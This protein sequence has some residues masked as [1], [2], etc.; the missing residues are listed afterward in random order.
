MKTNSKILSYV[1]ATLYISCQNSPTPPPKAEPTVFTYPQASTQAERNAF[2][3]EAR[4]S[5]ITTQ[6]RNTK[7]IIEHKLNQDALNFGKNY[8]GN[9][10]LETIEQQILNKE[11]KLA[12]HNLSKII[13]KLQKSRAANPNLMYS[14]PYAKHAKLLHAVLVAKTFG[15]QQSIAEFSKLTQMNPKWVKGYIAFWETLQ[16]RGALELALKVARVGNDHTKGAHL[17]LWLAQLESLISLGQRTQAWKVF[18]LARKRFPTARE[19]RHLKS[20]LLLT[21]GN[22]RAACA[23][24]HSKAGLQGL[25]LQTLCSIEQGLPE[26]AKELLAESQLLEPN[27]PIKLLLEGY[28]HYQSGQY[29]KAYTRFQHYRRHFPAEQQ[30]HLLLK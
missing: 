20:L 5:F 1:V 2:A 30:N 24:K 29:E 17:Q 21:D 12:Y 26:Q 15:W 19:L 23:N 7:P 16:G 25:W 6:K 4:K 9:K 10:E 22:T 28:L 13:N 3:K 11:Y 18:H 8:E 27:S 14:D